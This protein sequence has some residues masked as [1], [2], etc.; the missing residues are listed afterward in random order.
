MAA[1]SSVQHKSGPRRI[2]ASFITAGKNWS[3]DRSPLM[4]AAIA[5]YSAFSLAPTLVMVIAVASFFFGADA[6]QGRLF[7]QLRGLVGD[8]AAANLQQM[9]A[10]AHYTPGASWS[11]ILS[12]VALA[13]GASATF[14]SLN[15]ALD[16]IWPVPESQDKP[17]IV[18]MVKVRLISFGLVAGLGFLLVVSLVLDTVV[19]FAGKLIFG[20]NSPLLVVA[21]LIQLVLSLV[22][23]TVAFSTLLKFLPDAI[24]RWRHAFIGGVFAAVLFTGGK[25][26]FALYLAHAGMANTFGAAGS[27]AVILMWLYYSS[28]VLLLGAELAAVYAGVRDN[29]D[30]AKRETTGA[31]PREPMRGAPSRPT[32][33][34]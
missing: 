9:V 28:A 29:G 17:G 25:K 3:G 12:L 7:G 32:Q 15:T 21:D 31:A 19:S 10:H 24:V 14:S 6:V 20:E 1:T 16:V 8:D 22:V 23:L 33:K 26:L 30:P 2:V 18:T 4:S 13:I 11:A 5:F 34:A 27:L